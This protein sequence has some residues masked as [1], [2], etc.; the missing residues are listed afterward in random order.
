MY[1]PSGIAQRAARLRRKFQQEFAPVISPI[2]AS[3]T[4]IRDM[5][6]NND[7]QNTGAAASPIPRMARIATLL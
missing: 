4:G 5:P 6:A 2:C 3:S 7:A 1:V